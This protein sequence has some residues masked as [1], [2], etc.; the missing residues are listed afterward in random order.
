M[1]AVA[2]SALY[3]DYRNS[4]RSRLVERTTTTSSTPQTSGP[5][6]RDGRQRFAAVFDGTVSDRCRRMNRQ[7]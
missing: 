7:P 3:Q 2:V 1:T 4:L 6:I 5:A